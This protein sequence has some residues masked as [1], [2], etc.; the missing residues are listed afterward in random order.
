MN[1]SLAK[2]MR[3]LFSV[4]CVLS[5]L[6]VFTIIC[7]A[8]TDIFRRFVELITDRMNAINSIFDFNAGASSRR[9]ALTAGAVEVILHGNSYS[10]NNTE[11]ETITNDDIIKEQN[12]YIKLL[13]Q[14]Q[15]NLRNLKRDPGF[16]D[17]AMPPRLY[18]RPCTSQVLDLYQDAQFAE[19]GGSSLSNLKLRLKQEQLISPE[20]L[21]KVDPEEHD[22][23]N[24]HHRDLDCEIKKEE[25]M[26]PKRAIK[27][28]PEQNSFND[29]LENNSAKNP[30][31][32][33]DDDNN[34]NDNDLIIM[35][36]EVGLKQENSSTES[37]NPHAKVNTLSDKSLQKVIKSEPE[38][39]WATVTFFNNSSANSI[40]IDGDDEKDIITSENM[41]TY[42]NKNV[43]QTGS[44][45]ASRHGVALSGDILSRYHEQLETTLTQSNNDYCIEQENESGNSDQG[46][47]FVTSSETEDQW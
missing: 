32:I 5:L 38:S 35:E 14:K 12:A 23:A 41:E 3:I 15:L 31:I 33:D 26:S 1:G 13:E 30:I 29:M 11:D 7:K 18:K 44:T 45:Y 22:L 10:I 28:E 46:S 17:I 42:E 47:L 8:Q 37:D 27:I 6:S 16:L 43:A 40:V 36:K 20:R 34:D 21:I 2:E 4:D 24:T 25:S 9:K 19:I 39:E